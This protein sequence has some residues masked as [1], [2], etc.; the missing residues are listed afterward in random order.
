[1]EFASFLFFDLKDNR[2]I[3]HGGVGV[4]IIHIGYEKQN[5]RAKQQLKEHKCKKNKTT[6][7]KQKKIG[8]SK[9]HSRWRSKIT[10]NGN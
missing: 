9:R 5:N 2:H 7:K 6:Q 3:L 10:R 1:M 8:G 4:V